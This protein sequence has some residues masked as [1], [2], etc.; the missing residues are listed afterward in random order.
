[1]P[2][3]C[4]TCN[5]E[6]VL[7]ASSAAVRAARSAT[8]EPSVAKRTLVGKMLIEDVLLA[9]PLPRVCIMPGARTRC[10]LL[11]MDL[12]RTLVNKEVD[13]LS[14]LAITIHLP[15]KRIQPSSSSANVSAVKYL[16]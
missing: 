12:P 14:P 2:K 6:P 13:H 3:T 7:S 16:L 10:E 15:A 9:R 1:M 8:L 4:T 11:R 5:S